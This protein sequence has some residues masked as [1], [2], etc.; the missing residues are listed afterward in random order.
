MESNR[1]SK[2]SLVI[3]DVD[4]TL[5]D[6][7]KTLTDKTKTAVQKL[8]EAGILF[9]VTSA[10]PPFGLE[11]IAETFNLQY[12]IGSFNGGLISCRDGKI[13]DR[14]PLDNKMIPEIITMAEDYGLNA[15]LYSDRHWY[16][17]NLN[18]FH[19]DHHK[20][21]LQ[22]EPSVI[23]NYEDVEGDIFKIVAASSDFDAVFQCETA[24]QQKFGNSVAA[25]RSQPYN[26]DITHPKANKGEAVKQIARQLNIP[27]AEIVTIGDSFN[28]ISMFSN[29]GVSIAMGNA[30][31]KVQTKAIHVTA[32]NK[33]E[34]F[35][36]AIDRF[37]LKLA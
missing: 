21:T 33:E 4:G 27:T 24:I 11:A 9:T 26:L 22:F 1:A 31:A 6:D 10:R 23:T 25:T 7:N 37:V 13:I 14:T 15:W 34:G 3:S 30:D 2:I 8:R 20:E 16:L 5:I 35:A 18:G 36:Q 28:D 32:S 17:K 29:S 12:P 19:V